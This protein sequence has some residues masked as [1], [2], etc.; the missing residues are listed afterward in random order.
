MG[1]SLKNQN[2]KIIRKLVFKETLNETIFK[3]KKFSNQVLSLWD[4]LFVLVETRRKWNF[5]EK[6]KVEKE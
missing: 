2:L 5:K 3:K 1:E 6:G 4:F